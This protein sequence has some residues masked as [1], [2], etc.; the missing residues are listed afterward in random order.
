MSQGPSPFGERLRLLAVTLVV[1]LAGISLRLV[2]MGLPA[3]VVKYGGSTLWGA[4]VYGLVAAFAL[5]PRGRIVVLAA[6]VALGVELVRLVHAPGL[7]AFRSTLAGQLLLGRIFSLW[8]L[9]AYAVG[10]AV[11]ALLDS[12]ARPRPR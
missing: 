4:M 9:V 8:N 2:P 11:A 10:I 1:V 12:S 6:L 3:G 5:R 7:D